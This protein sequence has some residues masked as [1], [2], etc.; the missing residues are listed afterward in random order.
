MLLD[1]PLR[2]HTKAWTMI[3]RS[4]TCS[5]SSLP[6]K[7]WKE[8]TALWYPNLTR[9]PSRKKKESSLIPALRSTHLLSRFITLLQ[10]DMFGIFLFRTSQPFQFYKRKIFHFFYMQMN[11]MTQRICKSIYDAICIS[12]FPS[13][14]NNFNASTDH[15][16][17]ACIP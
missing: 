12:Y 5:V 8:F 13:K 11:V 4:Q 17:L 1:L 15:K 9:W 10:I 16:Q 14:R 7:T 6:T 2:W 3:G